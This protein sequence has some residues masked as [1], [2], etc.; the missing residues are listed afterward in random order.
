MLSP[1]MFKMFL[2]NLYKYL[3][4][5]VG[6][7]LSA[8]IISCILYADDLILVSDSVDGLQKLLDGLFS[9]CKKWHMIVNVTKTKIIVFNKRK[10]KDINFVYNGN[11]VEIVSEYK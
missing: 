7:E 10:L 2:A 4:T 1:E 9:F 6:V 8:A 5:E 11:E 3:T